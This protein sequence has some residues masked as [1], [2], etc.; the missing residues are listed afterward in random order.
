[1]LPV[2]MLLQET[3]RLNPLRLALVIDDVVL[4]YGELDERVNR[5]A[6]A[7]MS[8]GVQRGDRVAVM[9]VDSVPL[10]VTAYA[11][12]RIGAVFVPINFRLRQSE[13]EYLLSDT[14]AAVFAVGADYQPIAIGAASELKNPPQLI[15][16]GGPSDEWAG[17]VHQHLLDAA[18]PEAPNELVELSDIL[19]IQYSSGTTGLPKGAVLTNQ[20]IANRTAGMMAFSPRRVEDVYYNASPF[21]HVAGSQFDYMMHTRGGAVVRRSRFDAAEVVDTLIERGVTAAFFV[22][23]MLNFM[24]QLPDIEER[25]FS[26]LRLIEY[27]SAPM[28]V[29]LLRRALE[30]FGCEFSQLFGSTEVGTQAFL[31]PD[32]HRL[33]GTE[34]S[35]KRLASVGRPAMFA[36]V[37]IVDEND[38]IVP[39]GVVGEIVSSSGNNLI[40]YWR[41]PEA[42][43]HAMRNGWFHSGDMGTYDED[44][45][46]YL[47]DRKNDMIIRAGENIYP[48]EIERVLFKHPAVLDAA[49]IGVPDDEW[50]EQVKAI[51]V[52]RPGVEVDADELIEHCRENLAS[53]K[54][55][56][57]IEF[58][59]ELPRNASGKVLKRELRAPFWE[60]R[61]RAI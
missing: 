60:G 19:Q 47:V 32:D 11:A 10:V 33:D 20:T 50:G 37:R 45:Y 57:T 48:V 31:Y 40:E 1:M 27:G 14:E 53:Y 35:A 54:K 29:P 58:V 59:D 8:L 44:G 38:Q 36:K 34:T 16:H 46:I 12:G 17:H 6:N 28:P 49:V 18:S 9:D 7:L 25:D 5:M 2:S 22:P 52:R 42:S 56:T 26:K 39:P 51:V 61:T 15:T 43:A 24:L 13:V 41:K 30:V 23:S 4:T 55:P 21:F 3:A